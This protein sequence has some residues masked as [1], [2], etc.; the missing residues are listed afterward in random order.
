MKQRRGY[1]PTEDDRCFQFTLFSHL[2]TASF[3]MT[4]FIDSIETGEEI[5][6]FF[7]FNTIII[8]A[9]AI[10][11]SNI[12]DRYV[13]YKTMFYI[14]I[15]KT[16]ITIRYIRYDNINFY[17]FFSFPSIFFSSFGLLFNSILSKYSMRK[18]ACQVFLR[19]YPRESNFTGRREG[20]GR[21]KDV[22]IDRT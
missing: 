17:R 18:L 13:K 15:Y 1:D 12:M 10:T 5:I 6:I 11:Y 21:L 20:F 8:I 2:P 9:F 22:M 7:L 3:S 19:R 14:Y 4:N 16:Y